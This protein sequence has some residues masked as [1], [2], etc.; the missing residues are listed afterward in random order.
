MEEREKE[1]K[2]KK[3]RTR[4]GTW[5]ES[6]FRFLPHAVNRHRAPAMK[7]QQISFSKRMILVI[8]LFPM[9]MDVIRMEQ[10]RVRAGAQ[11]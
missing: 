2:I 5:K 7:M 6:W 8:S 4:D 9:W 10:L 3:R 1:E 11:T